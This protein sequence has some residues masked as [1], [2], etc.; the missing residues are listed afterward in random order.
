MLAMGMP[1][2]PDQQ[3]NPPAAITPPSPSSGLF[4]GRR[5]VVFGTS[6]NGSTG[7]FVYSDAPA[8][9]NLI[10]SIAS[11]PGTDPYGNVYLQGQTSYDQA[12]IVR[13]QLS[14]DGLL[15]QSFT[16]H[17]LGSLQY[18]PASA[19][20][21]LHAF[22]GFATLVADPISAVHP[23]SSSTPETWQAMSPLAAGFAAGGVA[24]AYRFEPVGSAG[25]VRF[26]GVVNLTANQVAGSAFFTLPASYRPVNAQFFLTPGTLAGA[27]IGT[28]TIAVSAS[29]PVEI[30]PAG[31]NGNNVILDGITFPLG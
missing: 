11:A 15:V 5:V 19:A 9:G 6:S 17:N 7:V 3:Y 16:P 30:N 21:Y 22:G 23:G 13:T 14:G 28:G 18:V 8:N 31:N 4:V 26:R 27:T 1:R 29:G 2:R 20:F 10:A 24:P 12:N 25:V